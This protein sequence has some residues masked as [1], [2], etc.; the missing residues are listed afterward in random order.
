M[1]NVSSPTL[2]NSFL[3]INNQH[4][5]QTLAEVVPNNL[6]A[7]VT[8]SVFSSPELSCFPLKPSQLP[9]ALLTQA[10]PDIH[11]AN[12]NLLIMRLHVPSEPIPLSK[13]YRSI[14]CG[15][16]HLCK[17]KNT[18]FTFH[19]MSVCGLCTQESMCS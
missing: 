3:R 17:K 1:M 18:Y 14:P 9:Q 5:L 16:Y 19:Y 11:S 10:W 6:Y 13:Y 15:L 12:S 2:Y 8:K 7:H 4:R